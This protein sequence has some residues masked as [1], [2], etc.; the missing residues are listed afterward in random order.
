MPYYE[1]R[2]R[3]GRVLEILRYHSLRRPGAKLPRGRN[4]RPTGE[5]QA[6]RNHMRSKD[7]LTRLVNANFRPGDTYISPTYKG[8]PPDPAVA[9]KE[10]AKY[11]RR[12]REWGK[13]AGTEIRWIAVTEYRGTRIHHHL[14]L[15]GVPGEKARLLW[16]TEPDP[17]AR[18]KRRPWAGH[19]R[20]PSDTL[21]DSWD[22]QF[23]ARYLGKEE[24]RG[25]HRW[26]GSRNLR[27]PEVS[28]PREITRAAV[29]RALRSP[30]APKNHRLLGWDYQA[31]ADGHEMLY[32]RCLRD[33]P[34]EGGRER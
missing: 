14:I 22:W 16:Q 2:I 5:A 1:R 26:T 11:L 6:V 21:D 30:R 4:R 34:G 25:E 15:S 17:A 13:K 28:P 10:L 29:T 23:L 9:R 12:L 31:A 7:T 33:P 24:K 18:G 3:S 27:R 19:G 20:A 32:Q 8:E